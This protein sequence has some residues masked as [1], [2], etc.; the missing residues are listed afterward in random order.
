[1]RLKDYAIASD[2]VAIALVFVT[3]QLLFMLLSTFTGIN[4]AGIR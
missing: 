4:M 2:S 1:M 3:R